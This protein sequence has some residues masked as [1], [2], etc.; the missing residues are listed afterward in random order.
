MERDPTKFQVIPEDFIFED[1]LKE[2][3]TNEDIDI[4]KLSHEQITSITTKLNEK[5]VL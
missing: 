3:K 1:K 5:G 4:V 2:L